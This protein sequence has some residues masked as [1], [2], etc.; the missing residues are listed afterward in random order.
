MNIYQDAYKKALEEKQQ[1]L[2]YEAWLHGQY[3][4]ASI[5]AALS[6]KCKY[7]DK[8]ISMKTEQKGLD[9][10]DK[11]LLWIDDFNRKLDEAK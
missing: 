8:P 7:P 6:K 5:G 9:D 10:E 1:V 2:D 4:I 11:F 3:Q